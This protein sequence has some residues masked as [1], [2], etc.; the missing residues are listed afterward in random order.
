[1]KEDVETI[2]FIFG[3]VIGLIMG[4]A[5]GIL[6]SMFIVSNNSINSTEHVATYDYIV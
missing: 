3:V 4:V 6:V 5:F 2:S 1:M